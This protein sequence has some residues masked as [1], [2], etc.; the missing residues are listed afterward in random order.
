MP[1]DTMKMIKNPMKRIKSGSAT[2]R[3]ISLYLEY[4][5]WDFLLSSSI[6]L[7]MSLVKGLIPLKAMFINLCDLTLRLTG[8]RIYWPSGGAAR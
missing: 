3:A 6:I 1:V 2:R 7:S 4:R 5:N 8:G